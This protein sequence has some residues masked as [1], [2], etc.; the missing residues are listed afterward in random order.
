MK[1][2]K[3]IFVIVA[4]SL[5]VGALDDAE[6]YNDLGTNTLKHLSE[7]KSDFNIPTLQKLGIGNITEVNNTLPMVQPLASYGKMKEVS[8]GKDTL[9]GHWEIMGLKVLTPFPS[10]TD[11]GFP[12]ELIDE[13]V[14]Q[15]GHGVLGN[16]SA[17][18]TEI[19][20]DLGEEH[21]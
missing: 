6:K 15:T 13:L 7:S 14:K 19:I 5:G 10:F 18:G 4:G 16:C 3:R 9:T 1:K 17:S 21:M 11:T 8:V 20:K 2:F 12:Q